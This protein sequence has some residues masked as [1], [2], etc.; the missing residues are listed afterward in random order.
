M[1]LPVAVIAETARSKETNLTILDHIVRLPECQFERF[2]SWCQTNHI[3][4]KD[5]GH[6][7]RIGI[8]LLGP[9]ML[10]EARPSA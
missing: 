9:L 10:L 5:Y 1:A 4:S 6:H 3:T 7:G 2:L 8:I